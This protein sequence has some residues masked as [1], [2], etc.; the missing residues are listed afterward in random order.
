M[1]VTSGVVTVAVVPRGIVTVA[2]VI[3]VVTVTVVGTV[4]MESVGRETGSA[5]R[6][7]VGSRRAEGDC[8]GGVASLVDGTDGTL[9]FEPPAFPP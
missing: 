9:A 2:A 7:T 3:G 5:G 8:D 4:G 6:D 1:T